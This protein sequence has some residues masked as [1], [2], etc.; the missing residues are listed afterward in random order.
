MPWMFLAA[1]IF[2]SRRRRTVCSTFGE[3]VFP[4]PRGH[5][6]NARGNGAYSL[7]FGRKVQ[8]LSV[9]SQRLTLIYLLQ[10]QQA[11]MRRRNRA[12][13]VH[14]MA[15]RSYLLGIIREFRMDVAEPAYPFGFVHSCFSNL[16]STSVPNV[17]PGIC[18]KHQGL[19]GNSSRNR[20]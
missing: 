11:G 13:L 20:S 5:D 18:S 14:E 3:Q 4:Q 9:A 19:I 8:I 12:V 7:A 16:G 17:L 1:N 2:T 6:V 10:N 15:S